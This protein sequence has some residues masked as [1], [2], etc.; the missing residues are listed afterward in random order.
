MAGP[1]QPGHSSKHPDHSSKQPGHSSKP[2]SITTI[3]TPPPFLS[4]VPIF[5]PKDPGLQNPG[6]SQTSCGKD[7]AAS[8]NRSLIFPVGKLRTTH[9]SCEQFCA[10]FWAGWQCL[11]MSMLAHSPCLA[12]LI[13]Q[14]ISGHQNFLSGCWAGAP[15]QSCPGC[16]FGFA[17]LSTSCNSVWQPGAHLGPLTI[18]GSFSRSVVHLGNWFNWSNKN[19]G[20]G[21]TSKSFSTLNGQRC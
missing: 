21:K 3:L 2:L 15:M 10:L 13:E 9:R 20:K 16:K 17:V 12:G 5:L 19:L 8:G 11:P 18:H 4:L 7:P 6:H 1:K 14:M